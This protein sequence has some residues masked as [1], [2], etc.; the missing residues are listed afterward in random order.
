MPEDL[1]STEQTHLITQSIH[2]GRLEVLQREQ[3]A[4]STI[5]SHLSKEELALGN[6]ALGERLPYNSYTTIDWLHDL[7]RTAALKHAPRADSGIGKRFLPS[8]VHSF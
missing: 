8:A 4:Q 7:V 5:S 1:E 6:T 2:H 3:D